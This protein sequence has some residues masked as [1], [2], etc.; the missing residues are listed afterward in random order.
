M[1]IL[2]VCQATTRLQRTRG[3]ARVEC[4]IQESLVPRPAARQQFSPW[5]LSMRA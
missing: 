2:I 1:S 3:T 4:L 5:N